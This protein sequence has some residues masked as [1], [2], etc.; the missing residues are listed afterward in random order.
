MPL[1]V[2]GFIG[3]VLLSMGSFSTVFI[4]NT[5]QLPFTFGTLQG[6]G[7]GMIV[8]VC[9]STLN[10]YFVKKRTTVM[11]MCKA[12]QGVILMWYPQ[13]IKNIISVYGFRGTLFIISGIT[14]HTFPGILAMKMQCGMK[15]KNKSNIEC[16]KNGEIV[17]LLNQNEKYSKEGDNNK[18]KSIISKVG[19][20]IQDHL[21]LRILKDPV[22]CNICIGQSFVNFSDV[23]FFVLQPMLLFQ[24]GYSKAEVAMCISIC[25]GADVAGRFTLAAIS[26]IAH[27]N[28]RLIFYVTTCLTLL[29]RLAILQVREFTWVA[30]VTGTL[31]ALR[32]WLH[33]TSPLIVSAHVPHNDFPGAYA[34]M[35]LAVGLVN[36]AF[37]PAIGI[38]KDEY[39]DYIPAFYALAACCLPCL[40]FWA[41]EYSITRK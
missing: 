14:L 10:Y 6:I 7:F 41:I 33:V 21:N 26:S 8:P 29:S 27:I 37:A 19:F 20:I 12:I 34:L 4:S 36:V 16:G 35:L 5:N 23:T 3:A 22:Y 39:Q 9:Y 38:L 31:G 13:I 15:P 11:S 32:A 1:Q 28:V 17:D 30:I 24:Y 18:R 25:A 40:I 2:G